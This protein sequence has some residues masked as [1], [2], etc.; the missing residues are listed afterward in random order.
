MRLTSKVVNYHVELRFEGW[1]G[2]DGGVVLV[3]FEPF[4]GCGGFTASLALGI[5]T[6]ISKIEIVAGSLYLERG[7]RFV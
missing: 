3:T 4:T 2:D 6:I 1:I 5:K 7:T